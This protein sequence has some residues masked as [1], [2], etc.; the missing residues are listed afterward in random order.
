VKDIDGG[1]EAAH[2]GVDADGWND[3]H[4]WPRAYEGDDLSTVQVI[5]TEPVFK[6]FE[7][8]LVR[9]GLELSP[10]MMFRPDD[11][12]TY[13]IVPPNRDPAG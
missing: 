7:A 5:L 9:H 13:I 12:P 6:A 8:W 2:E 10:P 4:P 1:Y 3:A 11:L